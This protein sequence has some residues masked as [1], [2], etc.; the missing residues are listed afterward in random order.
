[1]P[2]AKLLEFFPETP[3]R[4]RFTFKRQSR[5]RGLVV[6][7][8]S[9]LSVIRGEAQVVKIS[10]QGRYARQVNVQ[11][12]DGPVFTVDGN[13]FMLAIKNALGHIGV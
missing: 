13:D 4:G 7:T 5:P 11:V 8:I 9:T 6:E 10:Q 2:E 3:K 12:D 1:M